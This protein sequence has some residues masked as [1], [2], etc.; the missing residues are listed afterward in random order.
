M[1]PP[2]KDPGTLRRCGWAA[3]PRF[4]EYHDA[5]WGVPSHDDRHLFEMLTLEGAQA[6]LSWATILAKREGYR[7][8]FHGFDLERVA[9]MGERDVARLLADPAIVRHEGKIRSTIGNARAALG[10]VEEHGSLDRFLWR[11]VGGRPIRNRWRTMAD[12][13]SRSPESDAMSRELLR[14]GFRFVGATT[15]YAFLQATGM[16]DDHLVG[17]FRERELARSR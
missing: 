6:G 13:P 15:C 5:E 12:V 8:L 11:F 2:R 10:I 4:W 7:R 9:R 14:R 3:D 17:C 16:V 1:S